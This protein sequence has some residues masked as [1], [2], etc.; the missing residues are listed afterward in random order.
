LKPFYIHS[1]KIKAM[2]TIIKFIT[3]SAVS[4][5]LAVLVSL[6][7][8]SS[9]KKG[10]ST[11]TNGT[12]SYSGTFVKSSDVVVTSATGTATATFNP[13]TLVL[14]YTLNWSGL[15]SNAEAMHFHDAGPVISPIT[16]F[17][18]AKSGAFSG[19]I[20]L[21]ASQATDLVSGKI[22][23]QIHTVNIPA[24]EIKATLIKNSSISTSGGSYSY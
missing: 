19:T 9:C 15:G 17:A 18:T 4:M 10:D 16:G 5:S 20:T 6:V 3:I 2:K 22:F 12:V 13:T 11:D 14:S 7:G 21:T 8:F 24:G 1:R 23:T